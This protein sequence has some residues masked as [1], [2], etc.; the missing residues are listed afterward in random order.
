MK[1]GKKPL[2]QYLSSFQADLR[3]T[4][5]MP[6]GA[7]LGQEKH[8]PCFGSTELSGTSSALWLPPGRI[9]PANPHFKTSK[10]EGNLHNPPGHLLGFF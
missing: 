8:K 6:E 9:I 2:F 10:D 5:E 4:K 3:T 1:R 7:V